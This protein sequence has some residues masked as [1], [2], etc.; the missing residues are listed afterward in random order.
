MR[1]NIEAFWERYYDKKKNKL[2][3]NWQEGIRLLPFS[4]NPS[5]AV[6]RGAGIEGPTGLFFRIRG[7]EAISAIEN[8]QD[9]INVVEDYLLKKF[10][11]DETQAQR[12]IDI[13][14]DILF[15]NGTLNVTDTSFLKYLPIVPTDECIPFKTR[16]KYKAGQTKLANLLCSFCNDDIDF[17]DQDSKNLFTKVLKEALGNSG[18]GLGDGIKASEEYYTLPY[19]KEAFNEDLKWLMSLDSNVIIRHIHLFLH[20]YVC[21]ELLQCVAK[22]KCEKRNTNEIELFYFILQSEKASISHDGVRCWKE[23]MPK[24]LL[25]KIFGH[26]QALDII[27]SVLGGSSELGGTQVGLYQEVMALLEESP[28]EDN[29]EDCEK[30]LSIYQEEKR[31]VFSNR[32]SESGSIGEID[33]KVDSYDDFIR[34]MEQLCVGLQSPSYISRMRKKFIDVLSMR[35]LQLRR[36]NYI[37]TLDNEMLCFLIAMTTKCER[38]K[39]EDMYKRFKQ[40]GI[41]FNLGTRNAIEAYLLKLN[42]LDRKSDSG[43]AQYVQVV[44]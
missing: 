40:Y 25:D 23:K 19:I 3:D 37:L 29:K 10:H 21:Y 44:L 36:G 39:L 38:V 20:F 43:E 41:V 24:K 31:K 2:V 13:M 9:A 26:S 11:L 30:L 35:L 33:T 18:S 7:N 1:I 14:K 8:P 22:L 27:N 6:D 17:S 28:F 15:I 42:L 5:S 32:A 34:K 4:S 16:K 12:F